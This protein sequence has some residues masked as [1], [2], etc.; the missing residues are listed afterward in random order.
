MSFLLPTIQMLV[1]FPQKFGKGLDDVHPFSDTSGVDVLL[2]E[3]EYMLSLD[4]DAVGP[5]NAARIWG[6]MSK[7]VMLD[8]FSKAL[9][10]ANVYPGVRVPKT[11]C[12]LSYIGTASKVSVIFINSMASF[13]CLCFRS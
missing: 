11:M 8:R 10:V 1:S 3:S 5:K 6:F 2:R 4:L 13:T 9:G 7:F 12:S